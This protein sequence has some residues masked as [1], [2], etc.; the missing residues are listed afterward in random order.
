MPPIFNL[1][2][3]IPA[4]IVI[5]RW[6]WPLPLPL[7]AKIAVGVVMLTASQF[8]LWSRL[9][10]GSIFAPEFP[11]PIVILFN[12]AFGALVLLAVIGVILFWAVDVLER[13]AL[14]W[15]ASRRQEF[16]FTS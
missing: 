16:Q 14:P 7:W 5:A 13:L 15:H 1:V 3:A 8:H 4:L 10:S 6:L 12:W 2:F 11:R 9:S